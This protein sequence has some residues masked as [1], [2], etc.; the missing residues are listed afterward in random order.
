[1]LIAF[2]HV[3][4]A[5]IIIITMPSFHPSTDEKTLHWRN[6]DVSYNMRYRLTPRFKRAELHYNTVMNV[7]RDYE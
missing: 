4:G 6:N 3:V 2:L 5:V 1:M 7:Q